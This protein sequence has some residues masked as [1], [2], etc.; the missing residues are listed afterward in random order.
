MNDIEFNAVT[1]PM[2]PSGK[3]F[4]PN[5]EGISSL[6][7]VATHLAAGMLAG[8]AVLLPDDQMHKVFAYALEQ[9]EALLK[10][11]A[12]RVEVLQTYQRD[13]NL[14]GGNP[15]LP[16]FEN[17]PPPPPLSPGFKIKR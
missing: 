4:Q 13:E 11:S 5:H 3:A 9:A 12:R 2:K 16:K 6:A 17:P 7:Y 10:A 14:K 15:K 8:T 1:G